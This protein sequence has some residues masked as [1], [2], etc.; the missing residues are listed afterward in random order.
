M[1]YDFPLLLLYKFSAHSGIHW[2]VHRESINAVFGCLGEVKGK[3]QPSFWTVILNEKMWI[4]MNLFQKGE[5]QVKDGREAKG[6]G[7]GG[8]KRSQSQG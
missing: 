7:V 8:G 1:S 3:W 2:K 5:E 4:N 6:I